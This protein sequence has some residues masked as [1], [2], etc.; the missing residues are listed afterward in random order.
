MTPMCMQTHD[1]DK[2]QDREVAAFVEPP[3]SWSSLPAC[4]VAAFWEPLERWPLLP[5]VSGG[6]RF[7]S[8]LSRVISFEDPLAI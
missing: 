1:T 6:N 3:E 7:W 4:K 8:P 5:Q 2:S